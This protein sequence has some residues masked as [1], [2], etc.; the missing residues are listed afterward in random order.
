MSSAADVFPEFAVVFPKLADSAERDLARSFGRLAALTSTSA[1]PG[2]V[3][4][5]VTQ[6]AS[7]VT[8]FSWPLK[9]ASPQ[10]ARERSKSPDL[11]VLLSEDIWWALADGTVTPLDAFG[12]GHIRLL[13]EVALARSLVAAVTGHSG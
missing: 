8:H 5:G 11:E 13:G 2:T 7:G 6:R 12:Q 10:M 9:T 3:S 1:L 4:F